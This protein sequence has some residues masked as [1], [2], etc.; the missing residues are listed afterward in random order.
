MAKKRMF[1]MHILDSDAFLDMPL[2]TQCLYFHLNMRADDDGFI[3]NPK[4][5][6]RLIG[7]SDDDLKLLIAKRFVLT[8]EDGV[9]VIKHWRMHNT[10]QGDR[11]TPTVYQEEKQSLLL[12]DNKSYSFSDGIEMFPKC[13]QNV[14]TGIGLDIGLDIGIDKDIDSN[15]VEQSTTSSAKEIIEYLNSAIG[16]KYRYQTSSTKTLIKARLNEKFTIDDFKTVIDNMFAEWGA[17]EKM[18]A[19][20]RPQTLFGTKF[21]SYLNRKPKRKKAKPFSNFDGRNTDIDDLEKQLLGL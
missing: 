11:Y 1:T 2:S 21:E 20:L 5:I 12:K 19:Y 10:I 17:D 6:Q 15:N 8:F 16:S 13:K 3:G 9:I 4:R 14:S 7:A 18:K